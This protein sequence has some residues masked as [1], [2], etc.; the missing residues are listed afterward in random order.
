[1]R[2]IYFILFMTIILWGCNTPPYVV[3]NTWSE[4]IFKAYL[5]SDLYDDD[6]IFVYHFSYDNIN[7]DEN[8]MHSALI[9]YSGK[10]YEKF[11]IDIYAP[12]MQ[13]CRIFCK[14]FDGFQSFSHR[15]FSH[16]I[17]YM[18]LDSTQIKYLNSSSEFLFKTQSG[19]VQV[20]LAKHINLDSQ[21][22]FS[23]LIPS[24]FFRIPKDKNDESFF[25]F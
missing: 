18:S 23:N 6:D 2:K 13:P 11:Y 5:H 17:V 1:M 15:Q 7:K 25:S 20:M 14:P 22:T 8:L 16:K 9:A 12:D 21:R 3:W 10:Y 4:V 19:L 24:T